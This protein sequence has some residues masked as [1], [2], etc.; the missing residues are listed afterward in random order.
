[1]FD[2]FFNTFVTVG[3]FVWI[4]A[5]LVPRN[6]EEQQDLGFGLW[7]AFIRSLF[8]GIILICWILAWSFS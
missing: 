1:M 2:N 7:C 8:P 5:A 4:I 6:K 3:L